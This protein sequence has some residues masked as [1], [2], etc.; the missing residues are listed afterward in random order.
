[1]EVTMYHSAF[2]FD[3]FSYQKDVYKIKPYLDKNNLIPLYD[4]Y[5]KTLESIKTE[6]WV[7]EDIGT[8]L[9]PMDYVQV[10][11]QS[12]IG[13]MLLVVLS[14]YL[15]P[16]ISL[17]DDWMLLENVLETVFSWRSDKTKLLVSGLSTVLFFEPNANKTLDFVPK[18]APYTHWVIPMYSHL[19][20]WLPIEEIYSLYDDLDMIYNEIFSLDEEKVYQ[21]SEHRPIEYMGNVATRLQKAYIA[22]ITMLKE[23]KNANMGLYFIVS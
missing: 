6:K 16:V 11:R 5:R 13:Y 2:I 15:H 12:D 8:S 22:A 17:N 20:G 19:R 10:K 7:L 9:V 3:Y 14:K 4:E 21:F 23:A 1:M 18:N